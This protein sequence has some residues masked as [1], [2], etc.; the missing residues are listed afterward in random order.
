[1]LKQ[2]R[3]YLGASLKRSAP[4]HLLRQLHVPLT[5]V[6]RHVLLLPYKV[7]QP[8]ITQTPQSQPHPTCCGN[9]MSHW[10]RPG[11]TCCCSARTSPALSRASLSASWAEERKADT[12]S[13]THTS[14]SFRG[15]SMQTTCRQGMQG[16]EEGMT[17]VRSEENIKEVAVTVQA[18]LLQLQWGVDA[19]HLRARCPGGGGKVCKVTDGASSRGMG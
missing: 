6:W 3:A 14:C 4:P 1:M 16:G 10:A 9:C 5:K 13:R 18:H 7:K 2:Q 17:Q 8:Q 19:H 15:A 12:S 11:G